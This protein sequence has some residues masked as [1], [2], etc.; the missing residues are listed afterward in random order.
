MQCGSRGARIVEGGSSF[1]M[2]RR[3]HKCRTPDH[4][5]R[6]MRHGQEALGEANCRD[7]NNYTIYTGGRHPVY[8]T[9]LNPLHQS[10][11]D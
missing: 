1:A 9:T 6:T 8:Y 10:L 4:S 7:P 11:A 2:E 3:Q 5:C